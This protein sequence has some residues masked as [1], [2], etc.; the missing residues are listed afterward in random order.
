MS[1]YDPNW[2]PRPP[3]R[4]F[5]DTRRDHPS[6]PCVLA[7]GDSWFAH[8]I[9]WN[10]LF[11][12]SAMGGYAIRR[13]ASIGDELRDMVREAPGHEPEFIRQLQRPVP[14]EILLFSGG[15]NDLLGD[16]L[17]D[18]LRHRSE[19]A[20]GW[21]GLIRDEAVEAAI[22]AIRR[23]WLRV[24]FRTAQIRPGLPIVV[25]GY[26]YPFPR[27]RG[28][29]IFWGRITVTGPWMHP[30]MV[31]EKGITDPDE[32]YK[33]VGELVDRLNQMLQRLA[34][35]HR[36][37]HHVDLRE[38]LPS[39]SQWDDEIHPRS[40]GFKKMAAKFAKAMDRTLA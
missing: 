13:L 1:P 4:Q 31:G 37:F 7:E 28:A 2:R 9:E 35:E 17:P 38:T 26:D 36:T 27:P 32:R 23:A 40:A 20:R 3:G 15:G 33:I 14:W 6:W 34:A 30:V 29:T 18:L 12:L 5:D 22:E 8:P 39:E 11:H 10:I 21:R 24:I 25:H 16:P 19:V